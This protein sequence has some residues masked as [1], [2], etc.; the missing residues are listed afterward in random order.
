MLLFDFVNYGFLLL[1]IL[2][3]MYVQF[4]IFSFIVL[5]CVL[6]VCKCVLYKRHRVSTQ[7]QFNKYIISLIYIYIHK[8]PTWYNLAVCL[9]LTAI[10]LYMFRTLFAS[11]L[12]SPIH[13]MT[14]CRSHRTWTLLLDTSPHLMPNTRGCHYSFKCSGGRTHIASETCRVLLQ[15]LI[16]I[17]PSCITL[18]LYIYYVHRH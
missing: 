3:F 8:E 14:S 10:K 16:N 5:F 4:R 11:I 12:R 18:V 2:I 15:L 7:L 17:L 1:C 6:F 9:L 13:N